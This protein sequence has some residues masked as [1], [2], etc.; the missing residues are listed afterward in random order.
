MDASKEKEVTVSVVQNDS[1]SDSAEKYTST[2]EP[3]D[4]EKYIQHISS[5]KDFIDISNDEVQLNFVLEKL[6][7]ISKEEA[8]EILKQASVYHKDDYNFREE[9]MEKICRLIEGPMAYGTEQEVYEN[10]LKIEATLFKY[11]SPYPEVRAVVDPTDDIDVP[12]ETFRAYLLGMFWVVVGS[13][14]NEVFLTRQP[15]LSLKSSVFQILLYPCG[16][17]YERIVPNKIIRFR[18]RSIALNPGQWSYKEQ[19]LATIMV[20][21]GANFSNLE[22]HTLVYKLPQFFNQDWVNFGF[23]FIANVSTQFFGFGL[24][25]ILRRWVIYSPKAVWPTILPTLAL[26]RALLKPETNTV[27]HGWSISKYKFFFICLV[28]SFIYFFIPDV[29]FSALSTFNWITW[30]APKNKVLAIVSGSILGIGINPIT[31]FD[32]AVINYSYPLSKPFFAICNQYVG[33]LFGGLLMLAMYWRNYMYTGHLPINASTMYDNKG[34]RYNL[35]AVVNA[36]NRLNVEQYRKYSPPYMSIGNLIRTGSGFAIYT[37]SFTFTLLQDWR[38]LRDSCI[39]FWKSLKSRKSTSTYEEFQDPMSVAI[40][41]YEEVPDWWFII[42]LVLSLVFGIILLAA[43]PL[44]VPV[45]LVLAVLGVSF[46][47]LLPSAIIYSVTG[48]QVAMNDIMVLLGGYFVPGSGLGNIVGRLYGWNID[49]QA[50]TFVS[51]LKLAHYTKLPPRAVFRAQIF[52]T[53][54]NVFVTIGGIETVLNAIPDMCLATQRDK[55]TCPWPNSIYSTSLMFGA[56]GP[57]RVFNTLYPGLKYCFLVGFLLAIIFYGL[58]RVF[59]NRMRYIHPVLIMA[60]V[61]IWGQTYNLSYYTM[62]LWFSFF[63][64]YYVKAR[65]LAWWTKY[66]YVLTSALTA[67]TAFSAILIFATISYT[68]TSIS[69]W[70]NKVSTAG[71]DGQSGTALYPLKAGE[72]FGLRVG[73]FF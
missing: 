71:I 52:A 38:L 4:R 8:I 5:S 58:R 28:T 55:F 62:G 54:L 72:T 40:R 70:G 17:L 10:D 37:L 61:N 14:I 31:S 35:T 43:Y 66:N 6:P 33:A 39:G 15:S 30:I 42:L 22:N 32:W 20:N 2:L 26:N 64:M 34:V 3:Y 67:G 7:L 69:W 57:D 60:G 29:L 45:W 27:V 24:A 25:G 65:Y 56:I 53:C 48:Y 21:A 46:V 23:L 73:E 9:T 18:G 19:M 44:G 11:Y 68:Q 63:F 13:F 1:I 51:D 50:E 47:L 41:K 16:K 59:P 12:I 36:D 49:E